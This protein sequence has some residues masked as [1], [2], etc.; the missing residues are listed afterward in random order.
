ME[1]ERKV[2][3]RLC[4]DKILKLKKT[5]RA[6]GLNISIIALSIFF[7]H[8]NKNSAPFIQGYRYLPPVKNVC[9]ISVQPFQFKGGYT[10]VSCI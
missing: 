1:K 5:M 3:T 9:I 10:C 2:G 8:I 4:F 7:F 6:V